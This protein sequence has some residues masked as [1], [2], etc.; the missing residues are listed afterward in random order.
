M[1]ILQIQFRNLNSL[2][3]GDINLESGPL[4]DA[5]IF[6]ITGPTGAGKSTILDAITLALYGRAARYGDAPNPADTMSRHTGECRAEVLFEVPRGR[7]VAR[8]ELRRARGKSEGNIQPARRTVMDAGGVVLTSKAGEADR[9]IEELTGLD[10]RRFLR[11]VLLAQGEFA[12]FLKADER[13]RAA[14]LESLTGTQIYSELGALAYEEYSVRE[15]A[16]AEKEGELG[17]IVLLSDDE[18]AAKAAEVERLAAELNQLQGERDGVLRRLQLGR[19][20]VSFTESEADLLR[21]QTMLAEET[22][23]ASSELERLAA[24]RRAQEFFGDLHTLDSLISRTEA[25]DA[26]HDEARVALGESRRRFASGLKATELLASERLAA[27]R[28]TVSQARVFEEKLALEKDSAVRLIAEHAADVALDEAL[29]RLSER[30]ANLT[31][32]R[33]LKADS[34]AEAKKLTAQ[35]AGDAR[36]LAVLQTALVE[37]AQLEHDAA[38]AVDSAVHALGALLAGRTYDAVVE[39]LKAAETRQ[40]ALAGLREAL[41]R[42][43]AAHRRLDSLAQEEADAACRAE[44]AKLASER[45][46]ADAAALEERLESLRVQVRLLE[47]IAELEDRRHELKAGEPCPLCGATAHPF[48]SPDARPSAGMA[49][50]KRAEQETRTAHAAAVRKAREGVAALAHAEQALTGVRARQIEARREMG[51]ADERAAVLSGTLQTTPETLP[52]AL[53]DAAQACESLA[54][55]SAAIRTADGNKRDAELAHSKRSGAAQK[56]AEK[57]D[58]AQRALAALDDRQAEIDAALESAGHRVEDEGSALAADLVPFGLPVPE[59]GVELQTRQT[60]ETRRT[61]WRGRIEARDRLDSDA[62]EAARRRVE[63]AREVDEAVRLAEKFAAWPCRD[64]LAHA[65]PDRDD[66]ARLAGSWQTPDEAEAALVGFH[67][68][69]TAATTTVEQGAR[70]KAGVEGALR[71]HTEDL[72]RRLAGLPFADIAGLRASRLPDAAAQRLAQ[73]QEDL[74]RRGGALDA[75]LEQMREQIA[76]MR[77][78]GAPE[79]ADL[80]ALESGHT[81]CNARCSVLSDAR[82]ALLHELAGDD[83]ARVMRERQG[84]AIGEERERLAAWERLRHLIGSADGAKFRQFAQGLSLDVLI[85][86]ANRHLRRLSERYRLRRV[87]GG[88]LLLEIID[89]HQANAARPMA[90]LSGGESFLASLALALGLSDLAGRNVRIDS[91]FID[92][93][94]G[95]L[96]AETLDLAVSALDSLRLS[97]KTV[98]VISHVEL[99]KERIPVQI[100]VEKR[101]GGISVLRVPEAT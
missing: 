23:R 10:Y 91:L 44:A 82:S 41:E 55:L 87:T 93:G 22:T 36:K 84:R 69:L 52:A 78:A 30:L 34:E 19:Q 31:H 6:A 9:L 79:A 53:E 42:Q 54:G 65:V 83:K 61:A 95:S 92:E 11:S 57:L 50:A 56:A 46:E 14:L 20:L 64:E 63:A 101:A 13:D 17:R 48:A 45:G 97:N 72:Q 39:E 74:Q 3:E 4:A 8:W 85:R 60:L 68:A 77:L 73:L 100:R 25:L 16:L 29:P 76:G 49:D 81:E 28:E 70:D 59:P 90:S 43:A 21:Q 98:G 2:P 40:G 24:H 33:A 15:R 66:A 1:K 58:G 26:A 37:A 80:P 99:L 75:R 38:Q 94:F 7:F 96:D 27:A 5:G 51:A 71:N 89:L 47:R 35:R 67:T 32:A 12:Q 18:R 88:A 62:R 86:H